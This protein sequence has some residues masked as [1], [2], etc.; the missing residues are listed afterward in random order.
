MYVNMS[1]Q[2]CHCRREADSGVADIASLSTS[3]LYVCMS[4][5]NSGLV[6]VSTLLEGV[7]AIIS[8]GNRE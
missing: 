3:I 4:V 7:Q 2:M 1:L 8:D 5:Q 6:R